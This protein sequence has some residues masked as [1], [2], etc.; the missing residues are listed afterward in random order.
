MHRAVVVVDVPHE[1]GLV[2]DFAFVREDIDGQARTGKLD[3]GCDQRS[4]RPI[5]HRPLTPRDVG[6]S[7]RRAAAAAAGAGTGTGP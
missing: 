6:P 4:D 5:T 7:W 2:G 3:V 1:W